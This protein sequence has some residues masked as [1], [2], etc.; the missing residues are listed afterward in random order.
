MQGAAGRAMQ[1]VAEIRLADRQADEPVALVDRHRVAEQAVARRKHPVAIDA[2]LVR[3][4]DGKTLAWLANRAE[5]CP[6]SL[7]NGASRGVIRSALRLSQM[8][9]TARFMAGLLDRAPGSRAR[10]RSRSSGGNGV[11]SPVALTTR[12]STARPR[13]HSPSRHTAY[14]ISK[15]VR[16]RRTVRA[17]TRISSA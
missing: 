6:S 17:L 13:A 10:M 12:I 5:R 1:A 14:S 7:R 3:V 11:F 4:V 15:L 9:M 2:A 8:T 16:P